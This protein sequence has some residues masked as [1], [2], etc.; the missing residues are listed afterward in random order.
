MGQRF[1]KSTK[2]CENTGYS[3]PGF[4]F[5]T[6]VFKIQDSVYLKVRGF[7]QKLKHIISIYTPF[8]N[9]SMFIYIYRHKS[10]YYMHASF[11]LVMGRHEFSE[12]CNHRLD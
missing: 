6:Q 2:V 3:M 9:L 10:I 7:V 12:D 11:P 1:L 4:K 8:H 5:K